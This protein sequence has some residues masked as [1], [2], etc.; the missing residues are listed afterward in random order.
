[1]RAGERQAIRDY[2][3][4]RVWQKSM[5][6]AKAVYQLTQTLPWEEVRTRF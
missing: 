5:E 2:K 3:D 6:L 4:L 1:M